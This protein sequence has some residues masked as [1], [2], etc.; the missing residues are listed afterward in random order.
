[1]KV[2][3]Y[4]TNKDA[5]LSAHELE[6]SEVMIGAHKIEIGEKFNEFDG[7]GVALTGSSCYNL[8]KMEKSK[9]DGFIENVFS[10]KGLDLSIARLS[11][12]S[13]DYSPSIYSYDDVKD[14]TELKYFSVKRDEKFIIPMIKEVLKVK[15]DLKL[16]SSPWSPPA[17]MKTSDSLCG[18][19]MRGKYLETFAEYYVK[20]IESYKKH[21]ICI[22]ALTPQNEPETDQ[23]GKSVACELHPEFEAE[24]VSHIKRKLTERGLDVKIWGHDHCFSHIYRVMWQL[25]NC[26]GFAD[27]CDGIAF[28]YYT[29]NIEMTLPVKEFCPRLE[30]HF[31]E[32]GPRLYDNYDTD[33]C[34]WGIMMNKVLNCG[35][36]S[37]TGWNLL[38]DEKGGP[39]IG[40]FFCGGL[41]TVNSVTGELSYSGQYKALDHFSRFIKKNADVLC[42]KVADDAR[43]ISN[44]N[45]PY[46]EISA[47]AVR[48]NDGK[49]VI[50]IVNANRTKRQLQFEF[51]NKN[52]YV[53]L[54]PDSLATVVC[55]E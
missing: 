39:N 6:P 19:F 14:D 1:M 37:F 12:G 27:D 23:S 15:N 50:N 9:R 26:P 32:G 55:E 45:E 30:L 48:N 2:T 17:W 41:V 49:T 5:V 18:G 53:E 25:E 36:K 38:L 13:S 44:Y 10:E 47:S 4:T 16:F 31:T 11:V 34:K 51:E 43:C 28:H 24:L 40:P 52:W 21:G 8:D 22:S 33:W 29:G 20:Y 7:F 54:L 35:Y 46:T 42:C 3:Q